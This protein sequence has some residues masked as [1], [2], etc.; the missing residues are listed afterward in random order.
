MIDENGGRNLSEINSPAQK[1]IVAENTRDWKDYGASWWTNT[2]D[3]RK[4]SAGGSGFA[5]HLGTSNY[6]FADGHV[7]SLRPTQTATPFN[8]WG[9]MGGSCCRSGKTP[10]VDTVDTNILQGMQNLESDYK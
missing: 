2:T 8:M 5:G 1:I 10:N 7:K 4:E 6:L 9:E 3:W